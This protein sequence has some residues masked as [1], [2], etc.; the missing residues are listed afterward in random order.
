MA[1]KRPTE[2]PRYAEAPAGGLRRGLPVLLTAYFTTVIEKY[3]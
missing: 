2:D 1:V 3:L